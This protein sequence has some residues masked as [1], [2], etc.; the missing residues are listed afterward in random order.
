MP[1]GNIISNNFSL[2]VSN[3][4]LKYLYINQG[5]NNSN[6]NTVITAIL[7]KYSSVLKLDFHTI[8]CTFGKID[9]YG[10]LYTLNCPL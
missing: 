9:M 4:N 7:F 8:F 10:L 2:H 1:Q 5:V 3:H 6:C